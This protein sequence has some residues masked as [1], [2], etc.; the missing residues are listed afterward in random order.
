MKKVI[1]SGRNPDTPAMR[2]FIISLLIAGTAWP[3][4]AQDY[5][6]QRVDYTITVTL[7]DTL[8]ELTGYV[9]M[10]YFNRSPYPLDSV[11]MH[12]WPNAYR[13]HSTAFARQQLENGS[14]DFYYSRK[15]DRGYINGLA[16]T[17]N[18][19]PLRWQEWHH[20]PDIAVVYLN[21][22]LAPGD[23]LIIETPFHVKIPKLFSR[24]GHE[25]QAYMI[26]QWYPKPAVF[27]REGWHPM[28]YLDQGEFYSEFGNY[29]VY[30][31][32]PAN[33]VVAASGDLL[34]L[35]EKKWLET[36]VTTTRSYLLLDSIPNAS[37]TFPPS[38]PQA[39][40]LHYRLENAHDFAWFAD[41]RWLVLHDKAHLP[42]DR[43][44]DVWSMFLPSHD[45]TWKRSLNH[46]INTLQLYSG[47]VGEYAWNQATAVDGSLAAGGGMEYPTVTVI[48]RAESNE[49][50]QTVIAHEVGHNWF[51]GMLGFN[52]RD[53]PWMDE[54]I[55]S[56]Y[57]QRFTNLMNP[58]TT[59]TGKKTISGLSAFTE[60]LGPLAI[61]QQ[62]ILGNSQPVGSPSEAF[63]KGNYF[64]MVYAKTPLLLKYLEA[65][66]GRPAFDEAMQ[67]FF[68]EWSGRHPG[69][70]DMKN[71]F[72]AVTG[73]DLG[74][75]FDRLIQQGGRQDVAVRSLRQP[76]KA[77]AAL[78]EL[79]NKGPH[80]LAVPV[81][82]MQG[83]SVLQTEW[84]PPFRGRTTVE[85]T[86]PAGADRIWV[87]RD[88][89]ITD[90]RSNNQIIRLKG[91]FPKWEKP[92]LKSLFGLDRA[93]RS[94]LYF[95]PL[96]AWNTYDRFMAGLALYNSI[97][98]SKN[99]E[100]V[101]APMISTR[102]IAPAG[103][104]RVKYYWYPENGFLKQLD[105]GIEGMLFQ[106]DN[107]ELT[108]D[109]YGKLSLRLH[110]RLR[111]GEYR[112]PNRDDFEYRFIATEER[113]LIYIQDN[114]I[115]APPRTNYHEFI[116]RH[117]RSTVINPW[118]MTAKMLF[119]DQ[120]G[121]LSLETNYGFSVNGLRHPIEMRLFGG[122]M[123][124]NN[125][126]FGRQ[127]G[128]NLSGMNGAHDF[129]MDHFWFGRYA[130]S[131]WAYQQTYITEGGFKVRT[132]KFPFGT[133]EQWLAS[134]NLNIPLPLPVPVSI[135][136][137]AAT[138]A[139]AGEG[140]SETV[141]A[142]AGFTLAPLRG[143][144]EIYFPV[145]M[146][147]DIRQAFVE[148]GDNYF[149]RI[150]FMINFNKLDPFRAIREIHI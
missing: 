27:D 8:H 129:L 51:Y 145:I 55:N 131:G 121:R 65:Y 91:M 103:V 59:K 143:I 14:T 36:L 99:L 58:Y 71:T 53:H 74:W 50:L 105:A 150:T 78:L 102:F 92:Q 127:F 64:L 147:R 52:E 1:S 84:V 22:T 40:T 110:A 26:S 85:L 118:D 38:A 107:Y 104:A 88:R 83:D 23:S 6:Q 128:F 29:D 114:Q 70:D 120:F 106:Y 126:L 97:Y 68:R 13:D 72:E 35:K 19:E 75:F 18:N 69:P 112:S 80:A 46:I 142:E 146:S 11:M 12:L 31:T 56:F 73:Q 9:S 24:M 101:L 141:I 115:I 39:K 43:E 130:Y 81:Q 123:M 28:P 93:D 137:D 42:S 60:L 95:A 57:E 21:H 45:E 94:Q 20:N 148:S 125:N 7:N 17:G 62:D 37:D 67:A 134:L 140:L 41:K 4:S 61:R 16:F 54:G 122:W 144:L 135:F 15:E 10:K 86:L 136:A 117:A 66:L 47:W 149:Q 119:G 79:E 89:M 30:I 113:D 32:L 25:G 5:W 49:S 116:Y 90:V 76:A 63:T 100:F 82:V 87:D 33:Y 3:A 98:P 108:N 77:K 138:Y 2:N 139:G 111:P 96:V 48:A 44:V 109:W 133:S 34:T 132:D 124:Y